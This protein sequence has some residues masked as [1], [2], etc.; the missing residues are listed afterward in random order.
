MNE[1]HRE[2]RSWTWSR[3]RNGLEGNWFATSKA[4]PIF[5]FPR[6]H[7]FTLDDVSSR[8]KVYS[9]HEPPNMS[10]SA[11]S[12]VV[13][14][15]L[16]AAVFVTPTSVQFGQLKMIWKISEF[17]VVI[18]R[19]VSLHNLSGSK[20][21]VRCRQFCWHHHGLR[22]VLGN[23]FPCPFMNNQRFSWPIRLTCP[24]LLHR[25]WTDWRKWLCEEALRLCRRHHR[26]VW[27]IFLFLCF[28]KLLVPKHWIHGIRHAHFH[29]SWKSC[30]QRRDP[31]F[32]STSTSG[33]RIICFLIQAKEMTNVRAR[34][35]SSCIFCYT[36][37]IRNTHFVVS[38]FSPY[39][40]VV[41]W[42]EDDCSWKLLKFTL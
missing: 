39:S 3:F 6:I 37:R 42:H 33:F 17:S 29:W 12:R 1:F 18:V 38:F 23:K 16:F 15:F 30:P 11:S 4:G 9:R 14:Y 36:E 5:V 31:I 20:R 25:Y 10:S 32:H 27:T 26:N 7:P 19:Q 21:F 34:I 8:G 13:K 35:E 22:I 41:R 40:V 24:L 2:M 28:A